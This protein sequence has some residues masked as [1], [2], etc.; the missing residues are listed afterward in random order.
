MN[1]YP[2]LP[3]ARAREDM[4]TR[5]GSLAGGKTGSR[6][7]GGAEEGGVKSGTDLENAIPMPKRT[8][9]MKIIY[10]FFFTVTVTGRLE[11]TTTWLCDD[12]GMSNRC[13]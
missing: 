11:S 3:Q 13:R 6:V 1:Y 7:E 4:T 2:T 9:G 8:A 5:A 12:T 10:F